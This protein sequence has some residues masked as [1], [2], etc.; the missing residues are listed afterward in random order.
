M[1]HYFAIVYQDETDDKC[2]IFL[3]YLCH[4]CYR[5]KMYTGHALDIEG[6]ITIEDIT[7]HLACWVL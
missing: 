3:K 4:A 6:F 1:F 5:D 2:Y 7:I